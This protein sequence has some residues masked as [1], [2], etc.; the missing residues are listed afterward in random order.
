MSKKKA[1]DGK[2]TF[3]DGPAGFIDRALATDRFH[4]WVFIAVTESDESKFWFNYRVESS[5]PAAAWRFLTE[6]AEALESVQPKQ[7]DTE[8][9]DGDTDEEE[10]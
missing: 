5:N 2:T 8:P 9:I 3:I 10:D 4:H 6:A 7:P 1:D